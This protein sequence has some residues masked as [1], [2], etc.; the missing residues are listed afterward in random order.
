VFLPY[1]VVMIG[2]AAGVLASIGVPI[3][4][5]GVG[6]TPSPLFTVRPSIAPGGGAIG[7]SFTGSDGTVSNGAVI[8]RRWLLNGV[9][10]S[11]ASIY[12]STAAGSLVF[13]ITASGP[14]GTTVATSIPVMVSAAGSATPDGQMEALIQPANTSARSTYSFMKAGVVAPRPVEMG[15]KADG[16]GNGVYWMTRFIRAPSATY[17]DRQ[18]AYG[19][20][21]HSDFDG[22]IF[23]W[24]AIGDPSVLS[25]VKG[26]TAAVAAGWLDDIPNKPAANP[27]YIGAQAVGAKNQAETPCVFKVGSTWV[28]FYQMKSVAGAR[29]QATARATS[30]D[31]INW[32]G[33][34][35]AVNQVPSS[36]AVGDGHAGYLSCGVNPFTALINPATGAPWPYAGYSLIGGQGRSTLGL[37]GCE[38]TITDNWTF[39]RAINKIGGRAT[40]VGVELALF[41]IDFTSIKNVRQGLSAICEAASSGSGATAKTGSA[42]EI[43]LA[44]DG[45]TILGQSH[46][47]IP[48]G[49]T[50]TF[51]FSEISRGGLSVFG[52]RVV[53]TYDAADSANNRVG[54]V[55]YS[56]IRNPQNT[57]FLP[58]SPATPDALTTKSVNFKTASAI[59][60]GWTEVKAGTVT[61]TTAFAAT[62]MSVT[63]DG[64][65][66][67]KGEYMLYEDVGFDPQSTAYVDIYLEDWATTSTRADRIP[68]IGISAT[69]SLRAAMTDA[70][71]L[72][73]GE[74]TETTLAFTGLVNSA[75]PAASRRSEFY[76]GIGYGASVSTTAASKKNLGFRYFPLDNKAYALG[77]GGVEMEEI[78]TLVTSLDKTKRMYVGFGFR[79]TD[80][81]AATER[82]GK[83]TMKVRE[84]AAQAGDASIG[85]TN[86]AFSNAN[87]TSYSFPALGIGNAGATRKVQFVVTGR[88]LAQMTS[89]G[90]ALTLSTGAVLNLTPKHLYNSQYDAPSSTF[91]ALFVASIP[92]GTTVDA[93]ATLSSQAV[94]CG[95]KSVAMYDVASETPVS[96]QSASLPGNAPTVSVAVDK[97]TGGVI[98]GSVI[99]S[100][101]GGTFQASAA[102]ATVLGASGASVSVAIAGTVATWSGIANGT[103]SL[104]IEGTGSGGAAV[105]VA[106]YAKA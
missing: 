14:G 9:Q 95:I 6:P 100:T 7:Q 96:V 35:A 82:V 75:Q 46:L 34:D 63:V 25:N 21:D 93:V 102:Q 24:V 101:S 12:V 41:N 28:M 87:A 79:G 11:T 80:T 4:G 29:N 27:I 104:L 32:T 55:A 40:P 83:I 49:D 57:W 84:V 71:F 85:A 105:I 81:A 97:Q 5:G 89:I 47:V 30:A 90:L 99:F 8:G 42:F 56:P 61:P 15:A 72:S 74:A 20:S 76:W 60:A 91:A 53:A 54:A 37:W 73:N 52:D 62:G 36:E 26:Y 59:P 33:I 58:L 3:P 1:S 22:G 18:F 103:S 43:L 66:A 98:I 23:M 88:S 10:V 69:K 68:F 78:T 39:I 45:V 67:T 48:R 77:E 51:D 2:A 17:P 38:N 70:V 16:F 92:A 64:T 31:G 19:S 44:N 65:Q 106:T 50:G 94:R 13:E 86:E